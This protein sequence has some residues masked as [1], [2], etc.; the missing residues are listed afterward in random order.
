MITVE[1]WNPG[2]NKRVEDGDP[3]NQAQ[4]GLFYE[5]ER[6]IIE[7]IVNAEG[8]E[9]AY[10]P[11][12]VERNLI[13]NKAPS[14]EI[15]SYRVTFGKDIIIMKG[16]KNYEFFAKFRRGRY[17]G[18]NAKLRVYLVDFRIDEA[19]TPHF[20]YY[21]EA[22]TVTCTV[23]SANETDGTLTVNFSQDGDHTVGV[24]TRTDN[25]VSEDQDTY[26][27]GFTPYTHIAIK[28]INIS[29]NAI[30]GVEVPVNENK[31]YV[32]NFAPLGSNQNFT[33]TSSDESI[34]KV[35]RLRQ[36]LVISGRGEGTATV[37]VTSISDPTI[38]ANIEVKVG[39]G[40]IVTPPSIPVTGVSLNKASTTIL[41]GYTE[42]LIATVLPANATVKD[43]TWESDDPSVASVDQI[44]TVTAIA[45]GTCTIT[46]TTLDGD[47]TA[48]C[49][50][51]VS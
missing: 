4:F 12:T 5:N 10:N 42:T 7:R 27:Y 46:V 41:E 3:G 30:S 20:N 16:E 29:D 14:D 8:H 48:E 39:A 19:G 23:E 51:T 21:T 6:N 47:F 17:T 35:S 33:Q 11:E 37:T 40:G 49:D 2:F 15:R 25:S 9:V 36:S 22:M 28:E 50:I 43:V 44:G 24:M 38:S 18:N 1:H 45:A 34:V 31:A 32:I 26:T 13:G